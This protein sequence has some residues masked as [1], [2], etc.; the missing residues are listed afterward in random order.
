[1]KTKGSEIQSLAD[2]LHHLRVIL[3]IGICII[4]KHL[5]TWVGSLSLLNDPSRDQI[6]LGGRTGE[7]QEFTA[8]YQ[9]RAGRTDMYFL[10]SAVVEELGGFPKLGS[11]DDGIIDEKQFFSSR[12][13]P[14]TG[15][16]FIFA[17]RFLWLW[18]VG[19]KDR[20][21]VGVYLIKGRAKGMPDSLA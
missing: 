11:A 5:V 19:M 15:I 9:R 16:S 2:L 14:S 12:I 6:Q 17:M 8:V 1:M 13:R 18:V 7:I 10:G 4:L 20:G 3:A 21:Q